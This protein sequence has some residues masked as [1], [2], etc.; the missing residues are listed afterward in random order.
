MKIYGIV[1]LIALTVWLVVLGIP[2]M[3]GESAI[4]G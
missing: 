2:I 1:L 4:V 3:V